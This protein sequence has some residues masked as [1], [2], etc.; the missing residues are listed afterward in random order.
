M[1]HLHNIYDSDIHFKLDSKTRT[2]S[3]ETELKLLVGQGDHN[4]EIFTFE[5]PR[6]IEQHDMLKCNRIEIHYINI[7]S[8]T[9]DTSKDVYY[10]EDLQ[11]SPEDENIVIF[12]WPLRGNATKYNGSLSFSISFKCLEGDEIT[13]SWNTLIYS[14]ISVGKSLNNTETIAQE[15]SDVLE[16]WKKEVLENINPTV[17]IDT[18]LNEESDNAIANSTGGKKIS[19]LSDEIDDLTVGMDMSNLTMTVS[20]IDGGN[21]LTLSDGTTEKYVD[22]PAVSVTDEQLSTIINTWLN[23]HPEATT[24]VADSSVTYTKL[25]EITYE[26]EP[27]EDE[28]EG[29]TGETYVN[30]FDKD[31]M[32]KAGQVWRGTV[33]SNSNGK[34][35]VVPI[36]G[37]KMYSFHRTNA[38]YSYSTYLD[39]IG[40]GGVNTDSASLY[41]YDSNDNYLYGAVQVNNY[42]SLYG[43]NLSAYDGEATLSMD[44]NDK[45]ITVTTTEDVAFV[46]FLIQTDSLAIAT[47]D[48]GT[49]ML[50][51]GDTCHD[52]V[53]YC[54][55]NT[56][57][58]TPDVSSQSNLKGCEITGLFGA[59]IADKYARQNIAR[60][61]GQ[62]DGMTG[63]SD[64]AIVESG[65][66][67]F[68]YK[69]EPAINDIPTVYANG[70]SFAD[71]TS[72][73]NE[74]Q[75]SF[76]YISKTDVF[77]GWMKIKWQG[78]LSL[79]F[80]KHNFSVKLYGDKNLDR[81][82]K[83]D[84]RGW[85][86]QNKFVW[87]A[88]YIDRS[89]ARNIVSARLWADI[90]AS[91]PTYDT[92]MMYSPNH[93]AVDGFPFRL[94]VN[95]EYYGL[96]TWNIPKDG[97]MAEMT[98]DNANHC[99]LCA[100]I[101][102]TSGS[103]ACNFNANYNELSWSVE[104]PDEISTSLIL[105][106]ND[107]INCVQNDSDEDFKVNIDNHLDIY[108]AIDY[109]LFFYLNG[110]TDSLAKNML[111]FTYDGVKWYCGAYDMDGTW[112][113]DAVMS[114]LMSTEKKCPEDY[115][116]TNSLL[117]K[118][119]EACFAQELHDRYF[120]LRETI[121]SKE[122]IMAKFEQFE[123]QISEEMFVED[124]TKN[125]GMSG[126]SGQ[127]FL[128]ELST[129]LDGRFTYVD[130]EMEAFNTT[131][132]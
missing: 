54:N 35:A 121:L 3:N 101:N 68:G 93:G 45:G 96:M 21:R 59:S 126:V 61:Q 55:D 124:V 31:T 28:I 67:K 10:A 88:N 1:A 98:E 85:G 107:V 82:M 105:S 66:R 16:K 44:K 131:T 69:I 49:I 8:T 37:G 5:I 129:W 33:S 97:W 122:Y 27:T 73:K 2:F 40:V 53:P 110:G 112:G 47:T 20:A 90:V 71:M 75:M 42:I 41:F 103:G 104:F 6:Y 50:E 12:S 86:L 74:V 81:K 123:N 62:L 127:T 11:V 79:S 111:L 125:S 89:H 120:D 39:K 9:R 32:I 114:A 83:V 43:T 18:E 25:S 117:W 99:I 76:K 23:E 7:S 106:F 24:T 92:R 78:N 115:L 57:T 4:S 65:L 95:G 63:L 113:R 84:L 80:P 34:H 70:E 51:E 30:L 22:I 13:Y 36:I 116:N 38:T 109:Y 29:D 100:E 60:L 19:K 46:K 118:R 15:Y 91:R 87:K 58:E 64:D 56:S 108:S 130:A 72:D 77:G 102:N 17:T 128:T 14:K 132:E 119:V 52:Y 26:G 94:Y 48:E